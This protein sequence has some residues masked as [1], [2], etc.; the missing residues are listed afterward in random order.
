MMDRL[1][2]RLRA[3][4]WLSYAKKSPSLVAFNKALEWIATHSFEGRGIAADSSGRESDPVSTHRIIWSLKTWGADAQFKQFNNWLASLPLNPHMPN[5][6]QR[7]ENADESIYAR[8]LVAKRALNAGDAESAMRYLSLATS[9]QLSEGGIP[10][11]ASSHSMCPL[12]TAEVAA[13]WF[14]CGDWDHGELA[15][16]ALLRS[17]SKSDG[18]C[19]RIHDPN[20]KMEYTETVAAF[21]EALHFRLRT[22]FE[23]SASLFPASI[24]FEDGRYALIE[25][26]LEQNAFQVV[27]DV[28]CGKGRFIKLLKERHPSIEAWAIDI[29]TTML[30]LLPQSIHVREGSLLATGMPDAAA[31]FVFCVEALEHAVNVR[32]AVRELSRITAKLG[33]LVIIDKCA[34]YLGTMQICDWEQWFDA[35]EVEGWLREEGF[36][37]TVK[38]GIHKPG[39]KNEDPRFITWTARK[40]N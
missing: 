26:L 28:G 40:Q 27:V 31:D 24:Q 7:L 15:Y 16:Q 4:G 33:T 36:E 9:A 12:T 32:A 37:V 1:I 39:E 20:G 14:R 23:R 8:A 35:D 5:C 18:F 21:L 13:L 10:A 6:G 34:R 3:R 19:A 38:R 25:E 2:E 11:F 22:N 30:G 17:V 29:S